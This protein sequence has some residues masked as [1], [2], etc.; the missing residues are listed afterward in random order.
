MIILVKFISSW[1]EEVIFKWTVF[2]ATSFRLPFKVLE[3]TNSGK[4]KNYSLYNII[5]HTFELFTLA[6]RVT[7]RNFN[8]V[9]KKFSLYNK[10][11][12]N[13]KM[14]RANQEY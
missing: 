10:L 4:S 1:S 3:K 12:K 14:H 11:Q 7:V 2:S 6:E 8:S 5:L 9:R 13:E